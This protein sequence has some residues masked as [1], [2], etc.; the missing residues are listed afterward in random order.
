ML[1]AGNSPEYYAEISHDPIWIGFTLKPKSEIYPDLLK[2]GALKIVN[3]ASN[4]EGSFTLTLGISNTPYASVV[5]K[6]TSLYFEGKQYYFLQSKERDCCVAQIAMVK[7]GAD[8][9]AAAGELLISLKREGVKEGWGAKNVTLLQYKY[10]FIIELAVVAPSLPPEPVGNT[11]SV[12]L[13]PIS[14]I[15]TPPARNLEEDFPSRPP[16]KPIVEEPVKVAPEFGLIL[17]EFPKIQTQFA[18]IAQQVKGLMERMELLENKISAIHE[19]ICYEGESKFKAYILTL[20]KLFLDQAQ[21]KV[22]LAK[23]SM[24]ALDDNPILRAIDEISSILHNKSTIYQGFMSVCP[25]QEFLLDDLAQEFLIFRQRYIPDMNGKIP[26]FNYKNFSQFLRSDYKQ[27]LANTVSADC[28]PDDASLEPV[29]VYRKCAWRECKKI[30]DD[31][32]PVYQPPVDL[33]Q[34]QND[35][36]PFLSKQFLPCLRKIEQVEETY[37]GNPAVSLVINELF[38]AVLGPL[39]LELLPV[40]IGECFDPRKHDKDPNRSANQTGAVSR[41]LNRGV[42]FKNRDDIWIQAK[43][44]IG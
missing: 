32:N 21:K 37:G 40:Q 16:R 17:E 10:S 27:Y 41:V 1:K 7:K 4:Q 31:F 9:F 38:T 30:L 36:N 24:K 42:K 5:L 14:R 18:A 8:R 44:T 6:E 25:R 43:V 12:A 26:E 34:L 39:D 29:A 22:V 2:T 15:A 13:P 19:S 35:W 3:Y 20:Q 11:R 23:R 28:E 33:G